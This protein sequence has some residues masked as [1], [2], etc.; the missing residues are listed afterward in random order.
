MTTAGELDKV[1]GDYTALLRALVPVVQGIH[2]YAV[3]GSTLWTWGPAAPP[4]LAETCRAALLGPAAVAGAGAVRIELDEV[5]AY[6]LPLRDDKADS[7]GTLALLVPAAAAT[8]TAEACRAAVLPAT[9]TLERE[10]CLRVRLLES[11]RKLAVQAAE[12]R[13]LH[14]VERR[15]Q[16]PPDCK[17]M[18]KD[19]LALCCH[20]LQV[21]SAGLLIPD[22]GIALVKGER[23]SRATLQ[24]YLQRADDPGEA[25]SSDLYTAP[26]RAE[27][28]RTI[29][30]LVLAG[31]TGT[32]FS[33]RRRARVG[34]YVVTHIVS[35]LARSYD[36]L[37]GLA[38]WSA[39]E[40]Q[41]L[42]SLAVSGEEST[43]FMYFDI[44]R[45][46]LAND[47]LG[48]ETG[49][50]VLQKFA[51][52]LADELPTHPVTRISGDHFAAMLADTDL[53]AA[54]QRAER[55]AARFASL[56]FGQGDRSYRASVSIGI[57][58]SA[59]VDGGD[60]AE[61]GAL[62]TA[63]VACGAAKD[64]GRGRVEVYEPADQS[65]VRR[66]DDIQLVGYIRNCIDRGR[67]ALLGQPIVPV[68]NAA[69]DSRYF[70]VL[71]RLLD[72]D[73]RHV[74]PAEFLSA[75]E[76]YQLM[77]D[78]DRWVVANTLSLL[79]S[80]AIALTS[81]KARF[82]INLSGQSLGSES[83][84]A[85]V[86][87]QL[88][89]SRVPAEMI[90]FEI[91]ETVAIA[92]LQRAQNFMHTLRKTGCRFSLDD[93]GTG[94]SSFSYL[95]LFPV[96]T[97]KIDGSFIRDLPTNVV[98]QS[99]VAAIAEVARVMQLESVAEFVQDEATL[100]LLGKLGITWAQGY[101]L[102]EPALLDA[103]VGSVPAGAPG[104]EA[105]RSLER[106]HR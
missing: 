68:R 43:A 4:G 29:G 47:T 10:L 101:L 41:M 22:K 33:F 76:R 24:G 91:T 53:A 82:A 72:G 40:T 7:V 21:K 75:A 16:G 67:L 12:E 26:I 45:L 87:H 19:I 46:H 50:K 3:D 11:Y 8:L 54:R 73:D 84:L 23:L 62:A 79:G 28:G 17:V 2:C 66:F 88:A 81:A 74:S 65:I 39:F 71:V 77:E 57:G 61:G 98:S 85:F 95:K 86:Q 9:R 6:L 13:L 25:E 5:S 34:Q 92:N 60:D 96:D 59:P 52:I 99:V 63:K 93:F 80:S 70:E 58:N 83:F 69:D 97:L 89:S 18:L 64:R 42:A 14:E 35:V 1:F 90:C 38:A 32:E 31:W 106:W 15:L 94:L 48:R 49:D 78:L 104:A 27:G 20:Y 30:V 51:T 103:C 44:D 36:G 102:G 56:E 100:D 105:R 37:T 55:I